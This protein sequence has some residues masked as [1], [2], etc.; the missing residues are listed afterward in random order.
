MKKYIDINCDLGEGTGNDRAVMPYISS[1]SIAC[2]GHFGDQ[3]TIRQTLAYAKEFGVK[4]GAHPAYPDPDNFGRISMRLS[5]EDLKDALRRQM[6][7]FYSLCTSVNHIKPHGALY[8]DLFYDDEKARAVVEV[9]KNY[10]PNATIYS[11]PKSAFSVA[12]KRAGLSVLL[13]GFGD[14]AYA[15]DG[16]LVS[17]KIPGAVYSDKQQIARQVID[18]AAHQKVTT[19]DGDTIPL[20][21][22]TICMHGDGKGVAENLQFLKEKLSENHIHVQ[23]L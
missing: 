10:S 2:G 12:A 8:N 3:E 4:V 9:I 17:R 5:T 11:A 7:L 1:C 16:Q 22:K 14:R 21:V 15:K 13:E 6:D 19:L 18:I 20:A 23:A